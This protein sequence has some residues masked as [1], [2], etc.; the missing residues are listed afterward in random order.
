[1]KEFLVI[2]RGAWDADLPKE[3]VQRAI[4]EFYG[5]YDRNLASG[6]FKPGSRL[7]REGK[8]VA[9]GSITDGPFAE[10]KEV[11][12]GY[13]IVVAE[14]LE[15]AAA[16]MAQNPTIACG[17]SMEIRPLDPERANACVTANETPASWR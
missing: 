4:D 11:I 5:W 7:A 10:A 2:S 1:M 13:W 12:G 16:F 15:A 3:T 8:L 9:K 14:S 17:L 6:R